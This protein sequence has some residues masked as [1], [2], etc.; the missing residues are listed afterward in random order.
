MRFGRPE[1]AGVRVLGPDV[2]DIEII[3]PPT[4]SHGFIVHDVEAAGD[5]NGDGRDD[6]AI[7]VQDRTFPSRIPPPPGQPDFGDSTPDFA[8]IVYG[9]PGRVVKLDALGANGFRLVDSAG[10]S[11]R[12]MPGSARRAMSTATASPI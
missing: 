5:V 3:P 4:A 11:F 10:T 6:I 2:A 12:D 1:P 9:G 7:A 8:Y